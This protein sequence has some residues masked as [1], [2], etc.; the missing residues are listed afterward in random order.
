MV[1]VAVKGTLSERV[2]REK[3]ETLSAIPRVDID[4]IKF[5]LEVYQESEGQPTVIRRA[6][7]FHRLCCERGIF[8][9]DNPL[10]GTLT[11]Y[12]YGSY[13]IPEFGSRWLKK[14]ESVNLQRGKA[15]LT[16]E[17][18][19]WIN[20]ATDYWQDNSVFNQTKEI[21]LESCGADIGLLQKCGVGTEFTPGGFIDVTPDYFQVLNKG[22]NGI[23]SEIEAEKAKVDSG[24][25]EG[26]TKW[27]FY[28]AAILCLTGMIKLAHR[29]ASLAQEMASHETN[30]ER[31]RE[32]EKIAEMCRWVPANPARS[33]YEALQS[34][35]FCMLGV[36][37][38]GPF[39]LNCPPG[40]FTQYLYPFYQKDKDEGK[41]T[42]QEAIELIQFFFLKLNGL[43]QVSPPHGVA[44]SQTRLGLHLCL[45]GVTPDGE[46]ATNELDWLVLEAQRQIRLPEPLVD[47]MYHDRLSQEFLLKC[48]ELVKTG[49]GQPAFHNLAKAI[50]RHLYHGKIPLEEARNVSIIGCVQSW[51]SGYSICPWEG[52]FNIAKMVELALNDGKDPLTGIQ[53]GPHTG[54]AEAFRS[55]GELWEAVLK[56][57]AYFIP[58]QRRIGRTAWN[59]ERNFPVPFASALLNDCVKQGKDV[60]DGG[61]RYNEANGMTF[62]AGVD[63]ANSLAAIKK[64]VF[65]EKKITMRRLKEALAADF[66]GYEDVQKMTMA[67]PKYGNGDDYVDS[68]AKQVYEVCYHE[69]QKFPDFMGRPT[70]PEAYSVVAHWATGRFTG[71]LPYGR[72]ARMPLTDATVSASPG[73]DK[74][75][76]TT[77]VRSAA[78]IIDTV[79][80]GGNHFNMKFHPSALALPEAARKLL[81]LIKTYFDL[82]GYH[83]QFNC[84]SGDT[85]RDAQ[86]HP[87]N[88]RDLVVRVAGFSA[89]FIYLERA[90]QDEII[91]RT[92]LTFN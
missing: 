71:A 47:L 1:Q 74:N 21:L 69:H 85:L 13:P 52:G 75:G 20:K 61:A 24:H 56:Q 31:K 28:H 30:I 40:R 58:L 57:M 17:E 3:E 26:L 59:V 42:E 4:R 90:V 50:E 62:F 79:K 32:L 55:Y 87:E 53:I 73:T 84:V 9:D 2:K 8:I 6:K 51:I 49:V 16:S 10:V 82:G 33:F 72:K 27:H 76:P 41:I 44:W 80:F 92:E 68:I 81:A 64:L 7:L 19:E 86:L 88:Y 91:R 37:M 35:W 67:A 12:K 60:M 65:E 11:K 48:V 23:L 5:L 38:E 15:S 22:L 18:R 14:V 43:A 46:D 39:Q 78:K 63:A 34:V 25:P 45:G 54:D 66:E 89:F 36:W 83:V 70:R 29:Y 77:L